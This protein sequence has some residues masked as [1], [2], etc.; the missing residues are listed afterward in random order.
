[1]IEK[2]HGYEKH[3]DTYRGEKRKYEVENILICIV[4]MGNGEVE[5]HGRGWVF[6]IY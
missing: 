5:K 4:T 6:K 2:T 1:M 3:L